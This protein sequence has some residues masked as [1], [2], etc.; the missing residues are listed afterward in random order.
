VFIKDSKTLH[1]RGKINDQPVSVYIEI[2]SVNRVTVY[3]KF[4]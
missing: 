1:I 3:S 4:T 2:E